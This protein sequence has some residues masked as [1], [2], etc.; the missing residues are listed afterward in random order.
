MSNIEKNEVVH[1]VSLAG[2][3]DIHLFREG[4]HD[5]L[6]Q[7]LGAHLIEHKGVSGVL[8][9]VWHL[10][11]GPR[12]TRPAGTDRPALRQ[13]CRGLAGLRRRTAAADVLAH[14]QGRL[15]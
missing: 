14:R 4:S 6:Y 11:V 9:A 1:G 12:C 13:V 7:F 15:Q 5:R 2:E 8:F 10:G 3:R